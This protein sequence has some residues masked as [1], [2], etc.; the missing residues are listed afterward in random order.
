MLLPIFYL[1]PAFWQNPHMY[2]NKVYISIVTIWPLTYETWLEW[3]YVA[4]SMISGGSRGYAEREAQPLFQ[5]KNFKNGY[6][7][8]YLW[9]NKWGFRPQAPSLDPPI[10]SLIEVANVDSTVWYWWGFFD[11]FYKLMLVSQYLITQRRRKS[12]LCFQNLI[13]N[14]CF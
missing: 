4:T 8:Y 14:I 3:Q 12:D 6:G 13:I 7:P 9:R 10:V 5:S 11:E 1:S 2:F